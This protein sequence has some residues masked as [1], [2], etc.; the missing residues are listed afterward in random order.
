MKPHCSK[1]HDNGLTLLEVLVVIFILCFL[2]VLLNPS[3]HTSG[4]KAQQISCANNLKEIALAHRIW[5]VAS[6]H[7]YPM[8]I[9][10]TNGGAMEQLASGNVAALFEVMSNELSS[11]K[12]L[13]CPADTDHFPATN[14]SSGFSARNI[15]YFIGVNA[16][17]G[18]PQ[19]M[20]VGD[21]NFVIDGVPVKSGLLNL[22][23]NQLIS[24]S[25]ARHKFCGNV[26]LTDGSVQQFSTKGFQ[27][28]FN[29]TTNQIAIP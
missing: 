29:Q 2:A 11:P 14:F 17:E 7:V 25:S 23:T 21:D 18:N 26:A 1:R 8:A 13:Y 27:N 6:Q 9:S 20:L 4:R 15:S 16:A 28:C 24:W 3:S 19:M 12:I 10:W 5:E 22:A